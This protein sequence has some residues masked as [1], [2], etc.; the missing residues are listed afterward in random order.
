MPTQKVAEEVWQSNWSSRSLFL[1]FL[2]STTGST[3]RSYQ[4]GKIIQSFYLPISGSISF[5]WPSL[6]CKDTSGQGS[7]SP[8][9]SFQITLTTFKEKY[10]LILSRMHVPS[11]PFLLGRILTK[12]KINPVK[13]MT[14][15]LVITISPTP[16][17]LKMVEMF[18]WWS[19]HATTDSTHHAFKIGWRKDLIV[20]SAEVLYRLLIHNVTIHIAADRTWCLD[21]LILY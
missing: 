6:H 1:V 8:K 21:K 5:F 17:S 18:L 13:A 9:N 10:K 20:L 14:V 11:A 3:W 16:R 15:M 7:W 19:P 2:S 4:E 12:K